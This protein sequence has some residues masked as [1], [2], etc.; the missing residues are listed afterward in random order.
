MVQQPPLVQS[1]FTISQPND[2]YEQ[3]ADHVADQVMNM[4]EPKTQRACPK[5]EDELP[6]VHEVLRSPGLPLDASTRAFMEPRFKQD[7]GRVRV[8]NDARAAESARTLNAQAYTFGSDMVFGEGRYSPQSANG[9]QLIAHELTHAVQQEATGGAQSIPDMRSDT[10]VIRRQYGVEGSDP[11]DDPRMHPDGAP[12]A[13]TCSP[14]SGCPKS[15]CEPYSS[16]SFARH[17]RMKMFPVLLA[18]IAVAVNSRVASLWKEHLNGGS[19]PKDLTGQFANDF[20][21]S[22]TTKATTDFLMGELKKSLQSSPPA[23]LSGDKTVTIDIP[24]RIGSAIAQIDD[25]SSPNQMNFNIPKEVPGNLAGGIGKDQLTCKAG[26]KP[27]PFNDERHAKGSA[28]I[29]RDASGNLSVIPSLTYTVK[30]TIDLCPGD[31]GTKLEQL[32]T[33]PI[34]QFEATGISGDVPFVIEFPANAPNFIIP[35]ATL[36]AP[37]ASPAP[38]PKKKGGTK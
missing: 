24:S 4:P 20:T 36:S 5:C 32:A 16:E 26:A 31:C 25:P 2:A 6:I 17:M 33:V 23:F 29:V 7:F 11:A 35:V 12:N 8:H 27:S 34:S 13:T 38:S 10:H 18:G 15:F 14:P 22:K 19:D 3:E 28:K 37:K 9:R 21:N 30:D 1:E